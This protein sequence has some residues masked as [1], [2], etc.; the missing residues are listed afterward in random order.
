M[1]QHFVIVYLLQNFTFACNFAVDSTPMSNLNQTPGLLQEYSRYLASKELDEAKKAI[2]EINDLITSEIN[3]GWEL[4]RFADDLLRKDGCSEKSIPVYIAAA[5]LFKKQGDLM[6]MSWC[7]G[8]GWKKTG[9][10]AA[11]VKMIERDV[12]M[13]QVVKYHVIPIM[14]GV[15]NQLLEVTSVSENVKSEGMSLVL[16]YIARSEE[17]VHEDKAEEVEMKESKCIVV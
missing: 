8:G 14:H 7:V 15:K 1:V 10:H 5:S 4:R 9:I 2:K 12:T 16:E 13:K 6:W 17:L 11:N 3:A